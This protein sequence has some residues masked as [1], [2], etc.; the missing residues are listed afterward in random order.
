VGRESRT[1]L[2]PGDLITRENTGDKRLGLSSLLGPDQRAITVKVDEV[3]GVAGF[4]V[5]GD[6]V[7]VVVTVDKG[8]YDKNPVSKILFQN[9]K[10]LGTDQKMESRMGD[11]PKI[12]RTVTLE[13]SPE[14]GERLAL[15]AREQHISL[16]LRGRGDQ[17][18][19]PT[20][21]VDTATL[22]G[23]PAKAKKSVLPPRRTVDVIRGV[24][25]SPIEF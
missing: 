16:V 20:I 24:Q 13:V 19:V 25:R 6:R 21:G 23:L 15:A 11:Q 10:V 9:L 2:K 4:P 8:V 12:V 5:I 17:K 22:L 14:E 7:D 3:T 18:L 1:S